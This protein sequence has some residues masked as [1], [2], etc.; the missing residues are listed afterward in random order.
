[1][2]HHTRLPR[3]LP[4]PVVAGREALFADA[5]VNGH[6]VEALVLRG[7]DVVRAIDVYPEKTSEDY[8]VWTIGE[9]VQ[10]FEDLASQAD[11]FR[12]SLFRLRPRR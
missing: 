12:Y 3:G 10:A 4:E 6:L 7:W 9:L 8:R 11:P 2:T 1:V 5:C